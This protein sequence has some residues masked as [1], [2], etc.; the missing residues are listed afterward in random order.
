MR[1]LIYKDV[2]LF[3]KSIE[4]RMLLLVAAIIVFLLIKAGPYAGLMGSIM[5]AMTAGI[6]NI[7]SFASDEKANWKKYQMAMPIS[8]YAVVISKYLSVICIL[9][10]CIA[11][12]I[13][14]NLISSVVNGHWDLTLY[15][16]SIMASILVPLVWTAICL[17]L[18]YWFGFRAAQ[19]MGLICIFP[20]IYVIKFF[21]D[22]PGLATL[23]GTMTAFILI[24]LV[25]C[26]VLLVLSFFLS[27]AG[28]SKKK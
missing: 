24:P 8:N 2:R 1:G 21:E 7:M 22:G 4:K 26:I 27:V 25:G 10:P 16:L 9:F 6:Q 14:L 13:I 19:T 3:Y 11:G 28:Y 18:T 12:S 15:G 23:P 5:L 17:P 20:M